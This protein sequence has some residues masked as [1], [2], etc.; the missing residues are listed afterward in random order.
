ML[1]NTLHTINKKTTPRTVIRARNSRS[2]HGFKLYS[3]IRS[4][5]RCNYRKKAAFW[6]GNRKSNRYILLFCG[7]VLWKR[8]FLQ[9]YRKKCFF[10]QKPLVFLNAQGLIGPQSHSDADMKCVWVHDNFLQGFWDFSHVFDAY[11]KITSHN[12]I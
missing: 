4:C 10:F 11:L 8:L 5:N 12:L 3:T 9:T 2:T 6:V 1:A 7:K